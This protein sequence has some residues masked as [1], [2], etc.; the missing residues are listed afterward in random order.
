MIKK[1]SYK[2]SPLILS[3][4]LIFILLTST[5]FAQLDEQIEFE[6]PRVI[7]PG[8][9]WRI[10]DFALSFRFLPATEDSVFFA[11]QKRENF[12]RKGGENN[13]LLN[14]W[15]EQGKSLFR[16]QVSRSPD[17]DSDI[18]INQKIF[19]WSTQHGSYQYIPEEVLAPGRWYWRI[20]CEVDEEVPGVRSISPWSEA[21]TI[22][23]IGPNSPNYSTLEEGQKYRYEISNTNPLMVITDLEDLQNTTSE[24][25]A[26]PTR[27]SFALDAFSPDKQKHVAP[28]LE[29]RNKSDD[30]FEIADQTLESSGALAYYENLE[31][32]TAYKSMLFHNLSLAEQDWFYRNFES[33]IGT[34][35]G[36]NEDLPV[37]GYNGMNDGFELMN[38]RYYHRS[39]Q[40]A[41]LHG[42][43]FMNAQF[44]NTGNLH[45]A[46]DPEAFFHEENEV[47]F[48]EEYGDHIIFGTKNNGT[49]AQHVQNGQWYGLWLDGLISNRCHWMEHYFTRNAN[50]HNEIDFPLFKSFTRTITPMSLQ[51]AEMAHSASVG[52]TVFVMR[53][54]DETYQNDDRGVAERWATKDHIFKLYEKLIDEKLIPSL[55]DAR[56]FSP[57]A[58]ELLKRKDFEVAHKPVDGPD[59]MA[60]DYYLDYFGLFN[61][62]YNL[63]D[64]GT[65]Y[66][67]TTMRTAAYFEKVYTDLIPDDGGRYKMLPF[68]V[69]RTQTTSSGQSLRTEPPG[70]YAWK[71]EISDIRDL[72]AKP[73]NIDNFL[74]P[75][76]YKQPNSGT[77]WVNKFKNVTYIINSN[78]GR[79]NPQT[80]NVRYK[81]TGFIKRLKGDI[82]YGTYMIAK[83]TNGG[84]ML[85]LTAN[86]QRYHQ[87]DPKKNDYPVTIENKNTIFQAVCASEPEVIITPSDAEVNIAWNNSAKT[88][89]IEIQHKPEYDELVTVQVKNPDNLRLNTNENTPTLYPNPSKDGSFW[90]DNIKYMDTADIQ[91]VSL[92]GR[93]VFSSKADLSQEQTQVHTNLETGVYLVRIN[94]L[95]P[96]KLVIIKKD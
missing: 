63:D 53:D 41:K 9:N 1:V 75:A 38:N 33:C 42:G 19:L 10:S 39:V 8:N 70:G 24:V 80:F 2:R 67:D 40:L 94:D 11:I 65:I 78:E 7:A 76:V 44:F 34:Y 90:I 25:L 56:K 18:A 82:E 52:T 47:R 86:T 26:D 21:R 77:A 72:N 91:I 20:R 48:F 93:L 16:L 17:F 14:S 22:R 3:F 74:D 81:N 66:E 23:L 45:L 28:L 13:V 32:G 30:R 46:K 15:E 6:A 64:Y 79:M 60:N 87:W 27:R 69:S 92:D 84:S 37:G 62:A 4:F 61:A 50:K 83:L 5:V 55:A 57:K 35:T 85:N 68:I 51:A 29:T 59:R 54:N 88:I 12:I 96:L 89:T 31:A 95:S 43:Y 73:A 58:I 71:P 36:E 49:A